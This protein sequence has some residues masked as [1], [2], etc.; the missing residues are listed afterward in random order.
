LRA[1]NGRTAD[2]DPRSWIAEGR[3]M[4]ESRGE[5]DRRDDINEL[6]GCSGLRVFMVAREA[7]CRFVRRVDVGRNHSGTDI[8]AIFA[9]Q[10]FVVL[11]D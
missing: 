9:W 2:A 11:I 4:R 7:E 5:I 3:W 8:L 6:N 1:F 10:T